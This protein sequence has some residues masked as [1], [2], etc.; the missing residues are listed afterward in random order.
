MGAQKGD[1]GLGV[2]CA[3]E[4]RPRPFGGGEAEILVKG[5]VV[6]GL[7]FRAEYG[8]GEAYFYADL[9][10]AEEWVVPIVHVGWAP[11]EYLYEHAVCQ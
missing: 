7:K 4:D 11:T 10:G 1:V 9:V 5:D 8:V 6:F 3:G 2:R